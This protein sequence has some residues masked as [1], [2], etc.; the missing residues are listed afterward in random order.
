MRLRW[1][2]VFAVIDAVGSHLFQVA[3]MFRRSLESASMDREQV[4]R[5]LLVQLDHM[6]DA[7]ITLRSLCELRN[8]FPNAAID[9]LCSPWTAELFDASCDVSRVFVSHNNRFCRPRRATWWWS[10][11]R[12]G[13]RLRRQRYDVAFD[14]RGE[15]PIAALLWLTGARHRV[16]WHCGGGGFFLTHSPTYV[17]NRPE[18]SSRLA[19]WSAVG[20]GEQHSFKVARNSKNLLPHLQ[21][22]DSVHRKVQRELNTLPHT[23]HPRVVLH[24][25]AGTMAKRWP[26]ERWRMLIDELLNTLQGTVVLIGGPEEQPLAANVMHTRHNANIA[27][28]TGRL[29]LLELAVLLERSDLFIGADSGPAH[30]AAAM[31]TPTV[32]L[33]SGTNNA[34]QWRPAGDHVRAVSRQVACSPCHRTACVWSDHPCMTGISPRQVLGAAHTLLDAFDNSRGLAEEDGVSHGQRSNTPTRLHE[35]V[36]LN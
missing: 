3:R 8:N 22:S 10:T 16:G 7:V 13:Q 5:I 24:L 29:D 21:I 26:V 35:P 34:Q 23:T 30:L 31:E 25:G 9:V 15:A 27:D 36:R 32:V 17:Q 4:Q 11:L 14:V 6:G 20:L 2:M 28:W 12:W 19:L 1:R 18:L 33:F